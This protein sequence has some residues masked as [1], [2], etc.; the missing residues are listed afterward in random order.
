MADKKWQTKA[1]KMKADGKTALHFA[2]EHKDEIKSE[3][4]KHSPLH[5]HPR[6]A[7]KE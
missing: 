3:K 5:T 2:D 4:K 7:G 6:S 1:A